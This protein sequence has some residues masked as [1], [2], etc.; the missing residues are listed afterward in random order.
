MIIIFG[1]IK[2]NMNFS[3]YYIPN[4]RG[5]AFREV[6]HGL[7]FL[8]DPMVTKE[9]IKNY[10]NL[11]EHIKIYH[12]IPNFLDKYLNLNSMVIKTIRNIL[13]GQGIDVTRHQLDE[14]FNNVMK[15]LIQKHPETFKYLVQNDLLKGSNELLF[16]MLNNLIVI[17]DE[18]DLIGKLSHK[19]TTNV[20]LFNYLIELEI[21]PR[22]FD[23][24]IKLVYLNPTIQDYLNIL[25][26]H[27]IREVTIDH[28]AKL[29]GNTNNLAVYNFFYDM[30][31]NYEHLYMI[32]YI[33]NSFRHLFSD[34]DK[35]KLQTIAKQMGYLGYLS[36]SD[37]LQ[38]KTFE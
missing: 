10:P 26:N 9:D 2:L 13:Y 5:Y 36:E 17:S 4:V 7:H 8:D 11:G 20:R 18:P 6:F 25:K 14:L 23:H 29:I 21:G 1:I 22:I 15:L 28:I 38:I 3:K 30:I 19:Y 34:I 24:F 12:I 35:K 16:M 31:I 37:E 32:N 27:E 33:W